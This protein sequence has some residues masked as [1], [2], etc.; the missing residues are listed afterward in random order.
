MKAATAMRVKLW[1]NNPKTVQERCGFRDDGRFATQTLA[2]PTGRVIATAD[3]FGRVM[4][5]DAHD[6]Q[7]CE[8]P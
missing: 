4:L 3:N 1:S 6:L 2:D 7:V 8:E 5:L